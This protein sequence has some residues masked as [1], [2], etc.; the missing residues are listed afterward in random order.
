[1][2]DPEKT[3]TR[4]DRA[5]HTITFERTV[6]APRE[7]V[8][9]AWTEPEHLKHWWDPT[10]A[11]LAACTVDLRPGGAFSFTNRD[12]AHGPPFTGVYVTIERPARLVFEA[13]GA[14]GTVQLAA[15]GDATRMTVSIRCAS[16]EHLDMF[17]RI[18]VADG[19]ARTLDNLGRYLR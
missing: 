5:T 19:T 6:T 1:M 18:G 14:V 7:Q 15:A 12:S 16:A 17:V 13:M 4:I 11:P 10:G 9:A 3:Q 8:F 2:M